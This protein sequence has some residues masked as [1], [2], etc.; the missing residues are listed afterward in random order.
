MKWHAQRRYFPFVGEKWRRPAM[1]AMLE[2][3]HYETWLTTPEVL[4]KEKEFFRRTRFRVVI[5]DEATRLKNAETE[6]HKNVARL[7]SEMTILVTGTPVPS[8]S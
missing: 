2:Q 1:R 8:A 6:F 5:V 4:S 3:G 7:Q